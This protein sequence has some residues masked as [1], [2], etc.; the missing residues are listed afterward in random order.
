MDSVKKQCFAP[1]LQAA[2]VHFPFN[3]FTALSTENVLTAPRRQKQKKSKNKNKQPLK[4]VQSNATSNSQMDISATY[5]VDFNIDLEYFQL[6]ITNNKSD[7]AI[8]TLFSL[9]DILLQYSMPAHHDKQAANIHLKQLRL[10]QS[11][12]SQPNMTP[13]SKTIT[14]KQKLQDHTKHV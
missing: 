11:Q 2:A 10:L 6:Y 14:T 8:M 12:I 3:T 9:H 5:A 13:S 7:I 1:D 4:S